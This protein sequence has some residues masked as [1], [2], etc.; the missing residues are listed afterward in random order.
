MRQAGIVM[1]MIAKVEVDDPRVSV[2]DIENVFAG[3][4]AADAQFS[5]FKQDSELSQ[6]NRGEIRPERLSI[7]MRDVLELCERTRRQSSG[8]F[9]IRCN[10][11]EIDLCGIVKGWAIARAAQQM[12]RMGFDNFYVEIA[13]DIQCRGRN[14][15]GKPWRVGIR[16]P[17][18]VHQIVK[19]VQLSDRGVATSGNYI[20][21]RHIY[22]PHAPNDPLD[23][24]VSLT[25]IGPDILDADR[26]ATAA[27]AMG[28]AGLEFIESMPGLEGYEIDA[29]GMARMTSGLP[30]Y[31]ASSA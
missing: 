5:P 26:F 8:Y 18:A 20:Q 2:C 19:I 14:S 29:G 21:K 25:V 27:F 28:R 7:E 24:I 11:S 31:L 6:F 4:I 22:N 23:E 1:G 12:S 16:N 9:D 15:L 17:F 30:Q 3:L 10:S 13:G